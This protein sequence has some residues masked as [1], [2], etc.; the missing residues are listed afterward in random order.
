MARNRLGTFLRV[1]AF[2]IAGSTC[3]GGVLADDAL[4]DRMDRRLPLDQQAEL[5]FLEHLGW[6]I[7][8]DPDARGIEVHGGRP[9]YRRTLGTAQAAGDLRIR[10]SPTVGDADIAAFGSRL[11]A[12]ADAAPSRCAYQQKIYIATREATRKLAEATE[13][14]YY[15]FPELLFLQSPFFDFR[16]AVPEWERRGK[17]W[18]PADSC[19]AA[20]E[21]FYE[22]GG[23]ADCY[24]AQLLASFAT[25]YELYG[26]AEF[27]AAFAPADIAIGWPTYLLDTP[28]GRFSRPETPAPWRAL[29][30]PSARQSED[31]SLVLARFG[32]KAFAGMTGIVRS[33]YGGVAS[34][35]N[36][37]I[38]SVTPQA[39][40]ALKRNGG[41]PFVADLSRRAHEHQAGAGGLFTS[42][43]VR[44]A[45]RARRYAVLDHPVLTGIRVYVHPF[46]VVTLHEIVRGEMDEDGDPVEVILYAHGREDAFYRRYREVWIDRWL[47]TRPQ[48]ATSP[49][50]VPPPPPPPRVPGR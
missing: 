7:V 31:P 5:A 23:V 37:V 48:A 18:H 50:P 17:V 19:A 41:F 26:P 10:V 33:Q 35:Q 11:A 29:L 32:P 20:I 46:G 22:R 30:I 14:G 12:L 40:E 47:E 38:V 45:C 8:E 9:C 15:D 4:R 24:T 25:Q 13:R 1:L 3:A 21:A 44:E 43:A 28:F 2:W 6:R 34:N 39:V 49:S 16:P 42:G 27:D 36:F